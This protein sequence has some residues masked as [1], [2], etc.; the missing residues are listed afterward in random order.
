[1]E[2]NSCKICNSHLEIENRCKFCNEP[3]RRFC[4]TCGVMAEKI[5][6]PACMIIDVNAMLLEAQVQKN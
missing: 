2:N 6:H 4:H 1:M 5:A 3:T